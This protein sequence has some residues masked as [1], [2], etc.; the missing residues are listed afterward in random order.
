MYVRLFQKN[1]RKKVKDEEG[2]Q[3]G[4]ERERERW[5]EGSQNKK[6]TKSMIQ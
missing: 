1:R 6:E 2:W 3:R 5:V 4:R